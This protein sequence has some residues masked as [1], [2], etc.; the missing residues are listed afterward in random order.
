MMKKTLNYL[1]LLFCAI[2]SLPAA[3]KISPINIDAP[4]TKYSNKDKALF[5]LSGGSSR[6]WNLETAPK[7]LA[8]TLCFHALSRANSRI[9]QQTRGR[10]TCRNNEELHHAITILERI[11]PYFFQE[12]QTSTR[13]MIFHFF[14]NSPHLNHYAAY[15][16]KKLT[17]KNVFLLRGI[18]T[19]ITSLSKI[20]LGFMHTQNVLAEIE[21]ECEKKKIPSEVIQG[22]VPNHSHYLVVNSPYM[23]L[24]ELL[25]NVIRIHFQKSL[26]GRARI[27]L[28]MSIAKLIPQ[29]KNFFIPYK[30]LHQL[31]PNLQQKVAD[32]NFAEEHEHARNI[33]KKTA[34]PLL[35]LNHNDY[36][37]NI[38][39]PAPYV[40]PAADERDPN[41]RFWLHGPGFSAFGAWLKRK[42]S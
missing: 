11:A 31:S 5:F 36:L 42:T 40:P 37:N 4:I 33:F 25:T 6:F 30:T 1:L 19:I 23:H 18:Q 12:N 22:I 8:A 32:I 16:M 7:H 29:C 41:E 21:K 3:K 2:L 9:E 15:V 10:V 35:G 20:A 28:F 39:P 24:A 13:Q 14:K 17:I 38:S 34:A 27:V 26:P